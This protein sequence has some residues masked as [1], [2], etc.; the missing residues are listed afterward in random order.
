MYDASCRAALRI[1][2]GWLTAAD[3]VGQ[4]GVTKST[5]G[6][7]VIDNLASLRSLTSRRDFLRAV[8]MGGAVVLSGGLLAGC[9]DSSNTGGLTGP[10][11]GATLTLDFAKGDV[12]LFQY[13]FLLEQLEADFYRRV[14]ANFP[15]S[16]FKSADKLVLTDIGNHESV[17]RDVIGALL[18]GDGAF[19]IAPLYESLTFRVRADTLAYAKDVEDLVL[20]ACAGVAPY[21]ADSSNLALVTRLASVEA[22]HS[23]AIRDLISPLGSTFAPSV[24]ELALT[25]TVVATAVQPSIEEKLAFASAPATFSS[26]SSAT[27]QAPADVVEAL[28]TCLMVAQLQSDLYRRGLAVSG[29]VPTADVSVFTTT[30]SHEASHVSTLQ[31]LISSRGAVPR[32]APA[33][34]YA[35]KGNLPGFAF[36][37]AQYATFAMLAQALEDLGVRT[38]LGQL[39]T[40]VQDK[41]ALASGLSMHAVQARHAAEV[42]RLRGKK[43][44]VTSNNRDDLPDFM[45]VVYDGEDK[46]LQGSV[47]ALSLAAEVGGSTTATEAF[48][49]PLTT[50]RT[51]AFLALFLP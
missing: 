28:Q 8:A 14:V 40:L 24:F 2:S 47:N 51:T 49:E 21:F 25:P 6:P 18:G 19:R 31:S 22:R 36:L 17:H 10:G 3:P 12:A 20:G 41:A 15:S 37:P 39:A 9:E 42:R 7:I 30:G 50:A 5:E 34:D 33:F 13:L 16:D 27:A 23:A 4:V 43:G 35:A 11:T 29:L 1:P 48:D 32:S 26:A 45:Q 38:W 46:T 44:W